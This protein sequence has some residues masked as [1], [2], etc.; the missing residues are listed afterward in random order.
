MSNGIFSAQAPIVHVEWNSHGRTPVLF[1]YFLG[2]LLSCVPLTAQSQPFGELIAEARESF[3]PVTEDDVLHAVSKV[4]HSLR[5]VE[6]SFSPDG[7]IATSWRRYLDW[8]EQLDR[9]N[10]NGGPDAGFWK[11]IYRRVARNQPGLEH[12]S[13]QQYRKA[14][15]E[16]SQVMDA[17]NSPAQSEE[18]EATL[19]QLAAL[20]QSPHEMPEAD[21]ADHISELLGDLARQ[22]QAEELW[23]AL[24]Q[25]YNHPNVVL[26]IPAPLLKRMRH[27]PIELDFP[28]NDYVGGAA[29]RGTSHMSATRSLSLVPSTNRLEMR[30]AIAGTIDSTTTGTKDRMTVNT[31]G[32]LQFVSAAEIAFDKRGFTLAPFGIGAQ[33]KT[34][35]TGISS[36]YRLRRRANAG[37]REVYARQEADRREAERN[38]IAGLSAFFNKQLASTMEGLQNDYREQFYYP[39]VR[40]DRVPDTMRFRTEAG[41]A[42]ME[43]LFADLTQLGVGRPADLS[44]DSEWLRCFIHQSAINNFATILSDRSEALDVALRRFLAAGD[45]AADQQP[46]RIWIKFADRRPLR[47]SFQD[48]EVTLTLSGKAYTY[49][50]QRYSG[51]DIVLRYRL[52]A[53]E[54]SPEFVL[55]EA[56]EVRLPMRSDSG[57]QRGGVRTATLR[58]ILTNVL[59]RDVPKSVVLDKLPLPQRSNVLGEFAVERMTINDGWLTLDARPE[60]LQE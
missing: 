38:A 29:V 19:N 37:E 2:W 6:S 46:D 18:C 33:L 47:V 55:S 23:R 32:E 41:A 20:L 27:E 7:Q 50:K 3:Q 39:L 15:R 36:D 45:P 21:Y 42:T 25:Q 11:R 4:R 40:L 34:K 52:K 13:F 14:V 28:V 31:T 51:M 10:Q 30:F 12:T 1:A 56:P 16:L 57:R 9:L 26:E 17:A 24:R 60:G 8:D 22:Q 5:V 49:R 35:I 58:R 43:M 59:E 54:A 53:S 48:D 44:G